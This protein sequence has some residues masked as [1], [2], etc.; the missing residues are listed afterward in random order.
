MTRAAK[1]FI[2]QN[3]SYHLI[4]TNYRTQN[5]IISLKL[6]TIYTKTKTPQ[7]SKT[8]YGKRKVSDLAKKYRDETSSEGIPRACAHKPGHRPRGASEAIH[9]YERAVAYI[10][11]SSRTRMPLGSIARH[12]WGFPPPIAPLT[13]RVFPYPRPRA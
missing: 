6:L 12:P 13:A 10:Y 3:H 11:A 1:I 4:T 9:I 2:Y 5:S 8:G 7:L